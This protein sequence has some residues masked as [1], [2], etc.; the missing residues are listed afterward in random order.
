MKGRP[1]FE[2]TLARGVPLSFYRRQVWRPALVISGIAG[3]VQNSAFQVP[4]RISSIIHATLGK[5]S[6]SY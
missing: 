3:N 5:V 6:H 4:L 2:T 1:S